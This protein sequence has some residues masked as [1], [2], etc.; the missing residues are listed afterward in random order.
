MDTYERLQRDDL[1]QGSVVMAWFVYN[2]ATRD[3]ML[4]RKPMPK[5][6]PPKAEEK[7]AEQPH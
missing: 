6:E 7:K 5:P 2:A 1:M 4:P 3:G